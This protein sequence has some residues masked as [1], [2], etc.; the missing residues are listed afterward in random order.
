MKQKKDRAY[1]LQGYF[2][3]PKLGGVKMGFEEWIQKEKNDLKF[4]K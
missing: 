4:Y 2:Y 3:I 1:G